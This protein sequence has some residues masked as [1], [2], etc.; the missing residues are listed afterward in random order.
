MFGDHIPGGEVVDADEIERAPL[1]EWHHIA[2]EKHGRDAR[3]LQARDDA[4]VGLV[5]VPAEL[6]RREHDARDPAL[7]EL[8]AQPLHVACDLRAAP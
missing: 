6:V 3:L 8:L 4:T 2:V 1:G 5:L 7:D